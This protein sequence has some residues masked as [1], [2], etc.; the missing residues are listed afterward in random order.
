MVYSAILVPIIKLSK[1]TLK[2]PGRHTKDDCLLLTGGERKA[3]QCAVNQ[4][5]IRGVPS[6]PK[7]P[8]ERQD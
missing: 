6:L 4:S 3:N 1:N 5:S 7:D 8:T 2:R